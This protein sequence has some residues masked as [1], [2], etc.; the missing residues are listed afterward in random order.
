M[1]YNGDDAYY[2]NI[3]CN[4]NL[5]LLLFHLNLWP[6][7]D[8][9][10]EMDIHKSGSLALRHYLTFV[11]GGGDQIFNTFVDVINIGSRIYKTSS[12]KSVLNHIS[13][14][15]DGVTRKNHSKSNMKIPP[16]NL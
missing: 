12:I 13:R 9:H 16:D 3:F 7:G 14:L 6:V 5:T 11:D 10:K 1:K 2:A 8:K 4:Y 15:S